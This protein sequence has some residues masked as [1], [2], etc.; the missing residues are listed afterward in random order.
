MFLSRIRLNHRNQG[1]QR[2]LANRYDLH[3]TLERCITD[4]SGR[5]LWR[6]IT[7]WNQP[8]EILIQTSTIPDFTAIL[9]MPGNSDYLLSSESKEWSPQDLLKKGQTYHFLI[10]ANPTKSER[11][12]EGQKRG[13]RVPIGQL[14]NQ[15]RWLS[16]QA[17]ES[18][19]EI[20]GCWVRDS[21]VHRIA[22]GGSTISCLGVTFEGHLK[23][24]DI[25]KTAESF[26]R[27]FGSAKG[28]GFGLLTIRRA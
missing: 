24:I 14:D 20:M 1:V 17:A 23:V 11:R 26:S 8:S 19:F 6:Q 9:E 28:L 25:A 13:K 15:Y 18:G 12:L 10:E 27:G 22:K 21:Q 5:T 3:R 4:R 2:D 7:N 16:S